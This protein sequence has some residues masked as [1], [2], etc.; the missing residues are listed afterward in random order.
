[1]KHFKYGAI[2][3]SLDPILKFDYQK[4]KAQYQLYADFV[5][6]HTQE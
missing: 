5:I 6:S 1:M 2:R 3:Q 4:S